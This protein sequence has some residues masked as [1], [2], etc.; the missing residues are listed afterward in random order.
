MKKTVKIK[1]KEVAMI[2]LKDVNKSF[3]EKTLFKGIN[4]S[5]FEG[6]VVALVGP[7]GS[8][9]STLLKTMAEI[10]KPDSGKIETLLDLKIAYFPQEIPSEYQ[11]FTVK[12]F[13]AKQFNLNSEKVYGFI[14]DLFGKLELPKEKLNSVIKNLSGGEKTN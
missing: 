10:I 2:T 14:A 4:L 12:D 11:N 7:N 5:V 1:T 6:E 13:F 3:N 8:G 9:K